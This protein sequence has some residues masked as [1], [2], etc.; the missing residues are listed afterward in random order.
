[1]G[2]GD[3]GAGTDMYISVYI[4]VCP[5]LY[6]KKAKCMRVHTLGFESTTSCILNGISIDSNQPL[7]NDR[8]RFAGTVRF[9]RG[10]SQPRVAC[11]KAI[12]IVG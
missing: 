9:S 10:R 3:P 8:A 6:T 7:E 5:G 11:F 4:P 12:T 2:A 1:M